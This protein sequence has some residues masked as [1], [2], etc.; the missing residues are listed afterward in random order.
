METKKR[1]LLGQRENETE[2]EYWARM[3]EAEDKYPIAI[4]NPH[5]GLQGI[6]AHQIG[7][8]IVA[9]RTLEAAKP[10]AKPVK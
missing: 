5:L 9:L 10:E 3:E 6:S 4:C 8:V 2:A 1:L 7:E